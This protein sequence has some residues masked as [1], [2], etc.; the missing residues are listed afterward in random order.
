MIIVA[1]GGNLPSRPDVTRLDTCRA[2]AAALDG[3]PGYQLRGLSRWWDSAPVPPSEQPRYV[4]GVAQ[5]ARVT[6]QA[7][8]PAALLAALHGIE[9]AHFRQRS[10]PDAART[11]DLDLIDLD[12]LLRD[13]PDPVLPHPRAHQRRFVLSPL[14]EVAP[15]WVH[16]RLGL[17]VAAL[18]AALPPDDLRPLPPSPP[19]Q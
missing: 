15:G 13:G 10:V 7:A 3:I 16:P 11:I 6:R 5:L 2:A 1:I 14:A 4:N 8:D 9:A 12:G 17:G 19:L 18:L